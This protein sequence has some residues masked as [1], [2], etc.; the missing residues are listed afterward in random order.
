MLPQRSIARGGPWR[1]LLVPCVRGELS[2]ASKSALFTIEAPD[3]PGAKRLALLELAALARD[4][5]KKYAD[6]SYWIM[7]AAERDR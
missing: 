1:I 7:A 3:E 5:A 4:R 2:S 6:Q